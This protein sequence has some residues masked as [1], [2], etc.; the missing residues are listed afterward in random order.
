MS[1]NFPNCEFN[2]SLERLFQVSKGTKHW[3]EARYWIIKHKPKVETTKRHRP[4]TRIFIKVF[5]FF[6]RQREEHLHSWFWSESA[7]DRPNHF[8]NTSSWY[9]VLGF[10][11]NTSGRFYYQIQTMFRYPG[12][13]TTS[14]ASLAH[15]LNFIP[16]ADRDNSVLH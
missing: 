10:I 16:R 7:V 4:S 13:S 8:A 15:C 5:S 1:P 6:F 2:D 9:F 11:W 12:K 14:T 3:F